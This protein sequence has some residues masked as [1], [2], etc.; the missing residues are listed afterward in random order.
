[1]TGH[2]GAHALRDLHDGERLV[3]CVERDNPRV[4]A[5]RYVPQRKP[6]I[7]WLQRLLSARLVHVI[8]VVGQARRREAGAAEHGVVD[9]DLRAQRPVHSEGQTY[10]IV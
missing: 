7:Q 8:V 3:A 4:R 10:A 2:G 9:R 1:M 6:R 5:H